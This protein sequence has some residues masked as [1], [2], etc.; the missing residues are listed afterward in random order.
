MSIISDGKSIVNYVYVSSP[1]E[2]VASIAS[3]RP[4]TGIRPLHPMILVIIDTM[5]NVLI[6]TGNSIDID[7]STDMC[8]SMSICNSIEPP[9]HD[10]CHD[11]CW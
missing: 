10:Y 9:N 3:L 11:W 4:D 6:V 5:I 2:G 1:Y 7:D 8:N